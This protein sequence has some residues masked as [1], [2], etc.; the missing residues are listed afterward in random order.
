VL[1][2]IR[3]FLADGREQLLTQDAEPNEAPRAILERIS[4]D[5][6]VPLGDRESCALDELVDARLEPG[7]EPQTGPT[8]DEAGP[9]LQDEDV[10]AA[11]SG[12][13][14]PDAEHGPDAE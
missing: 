1:V 12:N 10:A 4:E 2:T 14:E 6:R 8:W 13:Y 9:R 5:G 3:L 7:P 11:M